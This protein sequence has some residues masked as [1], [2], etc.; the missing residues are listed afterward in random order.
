MTMP[1]IVP[2]G[3]QSL[4]QAVERL[5]NGDLAAFPT[6]TIYGRAADATRDEAVARIF[7]AKQRPQ[8]NPLIAH[9][10]DSDAAAQYATI[11]DRAIS[12]M[13]VYWPGP[14]TLVLPRRAGG[15]LSDLACAGLATV[16]LRCPAHPVAQ[17]L[18]SAFDR[19]VAAPSANRSGRLSPT[20][21]V[22]VAESLSDTEV[23][24]LAG[25]KTAVGLESTILDLSGEVPALLRP[26]SVT[27]EDLTAVVGP[28][29]S[30]PRL[31]AD[32]G[33]DQAGRPSAPGQLAAHYAPQTRLRLEATSLA[34]GEAL[35]AF[36]PAMM[37][38]R[39]A[40]DM[41]NLSDGGDLVQAA[42]NLFT[43]L[44]ELDAGGHSAIAVMPIPDEG[45]GRAINDRL[46]RA[47]A[48]SA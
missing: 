28:I 29:A 33:P 17:A 39:H 38:A 45:V 32:D 19:P 25:G 14:L 13:E 4:A 31:A 7:A 26:G 18:L 20:T 27:L 30:E 15:G 35:L 2:A 40:A 36:G 6:A 24:I 3:P 42:A 43:M 21:P 11:D 41:R 44:H 10:A 46:R 9:V 5:R 8:F 47:A 37:L 12:L 1:R 23:L 34:P 16:A 48:A 22:H